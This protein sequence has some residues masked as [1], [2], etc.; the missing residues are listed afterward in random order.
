MAVNKPGRMKITLLF[1]FSEISPKLM[2]ELLWYVF[3]QNFQTAK[4]EVHKMGYIQFTTNRRL[5]DIQSELTR[6]F[7]KL[8][9]RPV[10][11]LSIGCNIPGIL[12]GTYSLKVLEEKI[13]AYITEH[14][15][16]R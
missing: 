2:A 3:Q 12:V 13:N 5:I 6:K 7:L 4:M 11:G 16:S 14:G 10:E 1:D 9:K 15:R 8:Y